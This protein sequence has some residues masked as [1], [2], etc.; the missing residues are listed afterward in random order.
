MSNFLAVLRS[1]EKNTE[2]RKMS[3]LLPVFLRQTTLIAVVILG[4]AGLLKWWGYEINVSGSMPIGLYEVTADSIYVG[5]RVAVCL[6]ED[7][8]A[9]ALE[10]Q[11]VGRGFCPGGTSPVLKWVMA[12]EGDLVEVSA[13][14]VRINGNLLPGSTVKDFDTA[15]RVVRHIPAGSVFHLGPGQLWIEGEPSPRSF[16]SKYYGPVPV[17]S[18]VA[19]AFP[20]VVA[21]KSGVV[22]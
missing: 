22:E 16:G 14:G 3:G 8:A 1:T 18:V 6:P 7:V 15:N 9:V 10:R 4:G 17:T 5:Q 12:M 20:I 13:E 2:D 11:Y 19:T 21:T